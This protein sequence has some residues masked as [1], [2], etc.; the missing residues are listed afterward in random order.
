MADIECYDVDCN[1][2][3]KVTLTCVRNQSPNEMPAI[4]RH[5]QEAIERELYWLLLLYTLTQNV[6]RHFQS[7]NIMFDILTLTIAE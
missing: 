4:T 3:V 5:L 7:L 6:W 2:V 1:S